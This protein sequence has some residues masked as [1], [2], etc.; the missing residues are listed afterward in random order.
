MRA[1][2]SSGLAGIVWARERRGR[3]HGG[4]VSCRAVKSGGR[5]MGCRQASGGQQYRARARQLGEIA[6]HSPAKATTAE[7]E[8][9]QRL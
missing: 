8:F 3:G 9:R 4:T 7:G 2:A 5:R 6:R 1:S